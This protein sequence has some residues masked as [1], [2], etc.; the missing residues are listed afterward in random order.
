ML[1]PLAEAHTAVAR[2][3]AVTGA[4]ASLVAGMAGAAAAGIAAD[5]VGGALDWGSD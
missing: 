5:R 2:T 3:T 1:H 4:R